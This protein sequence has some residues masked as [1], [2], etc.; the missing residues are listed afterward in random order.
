MT[1][2]KK[3]SAAARKKLPSSS[4]CAPGKHFPVK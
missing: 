2:D 1:E 4:Y 3:L